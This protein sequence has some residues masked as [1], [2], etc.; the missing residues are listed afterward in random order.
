MTKPALNEPAFFDLQEAL[1][2]TPLFEHISAPVLE[3]FVQ[4]SQ[5]RQETKG[6]V[7]FIQEDKAEWFYLIMD[8][9]VKLFR[10]TFDGTEAVIDVLS[11]GHLFGETSVFENDAYSF[12]AQIVEPTRFIMLP[13]ALLKSTI[14]TNNQ[15]ALNMLS[16]MSA[17]RR[18]QNREIEHLNTQNAPQRIGCFLLRLCPTDPPP[19][20]TLN[21]PY[22]KTLIAS[23]L[24]MKPETFSRA[25]S[26]L[27]QETDI[28]IKGPA[29][30]IH[31]VQQ[32]ITYTC[33]HCS[34]QFPCNDL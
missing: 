33:N 16:S 8:G 32:L 26:K 19:A 13:T 6:K 20:Y 28:E 34:V 17:H 31:N 1:Q 24:G 11:S 30:T 9:W 7:L 29:V 15:L 14:T 27:K 18:Q 3:R 12:S 4:A 21:L 23:R 10:E 2:H 5:L 22:D 25:L